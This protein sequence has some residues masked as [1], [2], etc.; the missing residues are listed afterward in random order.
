[1][2][3][4]PCGT[5]SVS[6]WCTWTVVSLNRVS[7]HTDRSVTATCF[8]RACR[9]TVASGGVKVPSVAC[10][11]TLG[12]RPPVTMS[13]WRGLRFASTRVNELNHL[14]VRSSFSGRLGTSLAP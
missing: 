4:E 6:N 11:V 1:M 2:G 13:E 3:A 5:T 7:D 9:S 8:T 12:N 14:V 10:F